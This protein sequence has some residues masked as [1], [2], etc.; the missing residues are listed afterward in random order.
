[1]MINMSKKIEGTDE[2]K[3]GNTFFFKYLDPTTG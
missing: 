2:N 1:M 3:V